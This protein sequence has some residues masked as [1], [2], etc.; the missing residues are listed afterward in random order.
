MGRFGVCG[1]QTRRSN[2]TLRAARFASDFFKAVNSLYWTD[3]DENVWLIKRLAREFK[4]VREEAL[5]KESGK[6]KA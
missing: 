2:L 6:V 1:H 4:E 5:F 3:E